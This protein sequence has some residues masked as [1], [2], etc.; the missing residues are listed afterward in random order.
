MAV[1]NQPYKIGLYF[2][3]LRKAPSSDGTKK[4]ILD[5]KSESCAKEES[6]SIGNG[7]DPEPTL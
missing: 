4:K 5:N 2:V 6:V 7:L 1:C 3:P